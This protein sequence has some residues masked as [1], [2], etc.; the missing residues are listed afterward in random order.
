[1]IG[2]D[3]AANTFYD[4]VKNIKKDEDLYMKTNY[5]VVPF[6]DKSYTSNV[7][8]ILARTI[9]HLVKAINTHTK[10]PKVII[11]VMDDDII[12]ATKPPEKRAMLVYTEMMKWLFGR[13]ERKIEE[14]KD[15]LPMKAK[16]KEYPKIYWVEAKQHKYFE[17]NVFRRKM[18]SVIQSLTSTFTSIRIM[19]MKKHWNFDDAN[20]FKHNRFSSTGLA[21]YWMSVDSGLEYNDNYKR[22]KADYQQELRTADETTNRQI[23]LVKTEV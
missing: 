22:E 2:D 20:L 18:N 3:F 9:N 13:I 19:K 23:S 8:S 4:N 15:Q 12:R 6:M 1:M 7:C 5:D 10:L 21:K 17:N 14:R 11:F 16:C